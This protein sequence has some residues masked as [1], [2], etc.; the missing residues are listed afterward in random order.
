MVDAGDG[1]VEAEGGGRGRLDCVRREYGEQAVLQPGLG[2]VVVQLQ[3]PGLLLLTQ[4]AELIQQ[5]FSL[6]CQCK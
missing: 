4:P 1:G 5:Q 6:Q 3:H 2:V